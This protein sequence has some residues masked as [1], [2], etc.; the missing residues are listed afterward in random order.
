LVG[1]MQ[2]GIVLESAVGTTKDREQW[3]NRN[4]KMLVLSFYS[5][6]FSTLRN[7][8]YP[9]KLPATASAIVIG[10]HTIPKVAK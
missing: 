3:K 7:I 1:F 9:I 2:L 8:L 10:S 5:E 6:I 4:A